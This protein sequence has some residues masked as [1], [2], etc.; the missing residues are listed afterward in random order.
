[1]ATPGFVARHF[2]G[3]HSAARPVQVVWD[4]AYL[5]LT[6]AD[7]TLTIPMPQVRVGDRLGRA[8]RHI[9]LQDQ[10]ELVTDDH[11]GADALAAQ[12]GQGATAA[13]VF[14]LEGRNAAALL[15]LVIAIGLGWFGLRHAM[16]EIARHAARLV[17]IQAEAALGR[18]A[19]SALD[20]THL[21]LSRLPPERQQ[22]LIGSLAAIC[23][24]LGDCPPYR[25]HF[26]DGGRLG[27]NALALPGG[28][29]VVTDQL[30]HL[31]KTDAALQ[32]VLLHELGHVAERHT[33]RQAL[34]GLGVALA[35][36]VLMGDLGD[37]SDLVALLPGVLIQGAYSRDMEREADAYALAR[38]HRA[39]LPPP[40]LADL[41][42]RLEAAHQAPDLPDF[43]STHPATPERVRRLREQAGP[44]C[45]S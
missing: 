33:L 1:V 31:A 44:S 5:R 22:A 41:L 3:R 45:G 40:A 35:A 25:L 7:E 10:G 30:V 20:A 18:Q 12:L 37:L 16:P 6:G 8:P 19:L 15:A 27:A 2:D 4:A 24:R 34:A 39:C 23:A 21:E 28:D 43:L 17:P 38:M 42:A 13:W 11:A 26:R 32:G 14:R 29:L 9:Y 36:Q